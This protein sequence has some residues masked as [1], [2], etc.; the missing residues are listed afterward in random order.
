[1]SPTLDVKRRCICMACAKKFYTYP[2]IN[3]MKNK[4][5]EERLKEK[6]FKI[7][8]KFFTVTGK[9]K[10]P[11]SYKYWLAI[12]KR[13]YKKTAVRIGNDTD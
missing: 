9:E 12:L 10:Q 6:Q 11:K 5:S 2:E 1:M 13:R 7:L 4:T 8:D 3:G